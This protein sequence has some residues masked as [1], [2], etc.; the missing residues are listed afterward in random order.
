MNVY[1][2]DKTI[3]PVD[4]TV[5]F[6]RYCVKR[7]PRCLR[8]FPAAAVRGI[9]YKL[10]LCRLETFKGRFYRFLRD[11]PAD[12]VKQ[13]WDENMDR[14]QPWYL[15][16]KRE[17]D[18]IISAS[19]EFSIGEI[20]TRLGVRYLASPV[21]RETGALRGANCR[22]EEKTRRMDEAYPNLEVEKAYSDSLSDKPLFDRAKEAYLVKKGVPTRWY[23]K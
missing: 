14:I 15:A 11:I 22:A 13:Y 6:W 8:S 23:G 3:Y 20:C 18:L 17:D 16:Q 21:D 10:G 19:P 5:D 1:D 12:A 9:G 4:S 2:F 7:W